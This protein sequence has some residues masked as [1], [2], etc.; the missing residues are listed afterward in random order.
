MKMFLT[1][2]KCG[3]ERLS[4]GVSGVVSGKG[5]ELAAAKQK[6]SARLTRVEQCEKA[7]D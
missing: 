4:D 3:S 7:H 1:C 2:A 5:R 6:E